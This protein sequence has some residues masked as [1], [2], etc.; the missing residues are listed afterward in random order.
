V[1]RRRARARIIFGEK[2]FLSFSVLNA[3]SAGQT[4]LTPPGEKKKKN[5]LVKKWQLALA[6]TRERSRSGGGGVVIETFL[7]TLN[8]HFRVLNVPHQV[9]PSRP[10]SRRLRSN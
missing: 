3:N 2:N 8:P 5:P 6:A 7:A 4:F 1:F 10:P 9:T